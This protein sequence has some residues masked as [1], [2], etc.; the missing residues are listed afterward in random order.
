[1]RADRKV[2]NNLQLLAGNN[3]NGKT[4]L[5]VITNKFSHPL[6]AAADTIQE[7][8]GLGLA[9]SAEPFRKDRS[10]QTRKGISLVLFFTRKKK[11]V[12]MKGARA[13]LQA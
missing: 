8:T 12:L 7:I 6:Q 10:Y 11:V 3:G 5:L 2:R 13:A 9:C 1:M 4:V